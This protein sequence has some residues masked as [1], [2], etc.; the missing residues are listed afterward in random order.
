[1]MD[2]LDQIAEMRRQIEE[3]QRLSGGGSSDAT[4][5]NG[6]SADQIKPPTGTI[7]AFAG[8]AAPTGYLL[9]DGA[10]VSR[11]TYAVLFTAIG[12]MYGAGDGS[13]TFNLPNLKGRIPA[14]L[15]ATQAEF[16]TIGKT[17]G[18]KTHT[19]SIAEMPAHGHTVRVSGADDNNHTGNFDGVA[20]S[21][22][23]EHTPARNTSIVGSG[24]AHNNLQPYLVINF[25]IKT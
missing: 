2:L 1:M 19:L 22:A 7:A 15:D 23:G 16:D 25:I 5:L 6:L 18:A 4:T 9:C 12:T 20:D 21:D 10:A 24:N 17:G 8:T 13:T 14:G 11:T 3:L